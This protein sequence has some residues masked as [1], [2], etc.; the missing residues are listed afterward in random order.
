M[1]REAVEHVHACHVV[2]VRGD[3]KQGMLVLAVVQRDAVI[4]A[5][6][7]LYWLCKQD[8]LCNFGDLHAIGKK[9]AS[10]HKWLHPAEATRNWIL[11]SCPTCVL[12]AMRVGR[13]WHHTYKPQT[14]MHSKLHFYI[15]TRGWVVSCFLHTSIAVS[16]CFDFWYK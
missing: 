7:A 10:L 8:I 2:K 3:I 6:K 14:G 5:I 9:C 16:Q 13:K 11:V 15:H 4:G 12:K 1:H